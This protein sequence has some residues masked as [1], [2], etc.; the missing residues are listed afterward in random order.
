MYVHL[1]VFSAAGQ[2]RYD[3]FGIEQA[4]RIECPLDRQERVE[5]FARELHAHLIYFLHS[6]TVLSSHGSSHLHA[7][8]EYGRA[9]FLGAL[10]FV[11][12]I[13][14]EQD[15]RMQV[16]IARMEHVGATQ[17]ELVFHLLDGAQHLAR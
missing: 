11:R 17:A 2:R 3:L 5:F 13:R 10:H 4:R 12:F 16:A 1:A 9:E 6:H 14:I 8:F 15:Q 7:Q